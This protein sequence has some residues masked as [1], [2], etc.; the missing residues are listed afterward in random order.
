MIHPQERAIQRYNKQL[1]INNIIEIARMI[2]NDEHMIVGPAPRGNGRMLCYVK[3]ENIPYKVLYERIDGQVR[4]ITIYPF[5]VDEYNKLLEEKQ[6]G[7]YTDYVIKE[8]MK[9][10]E[11]NNDKT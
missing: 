3:Y 6:F 10:F 9:I 11:D 4:I 5:D 8:F 7:G 2:N 1:H